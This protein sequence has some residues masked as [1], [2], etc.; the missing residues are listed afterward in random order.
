MKFG[1][2]PETELDTVDFSLPPEPA[3]NIKVLGG[4]RNPVAVRIGCPQWGVPGW[5]GKIYP[6]KAKEK[7]F[8]ANYVQHY[9]CIELNATHYKIYDPKAIGKWAEKDNGRDFF[10]YLK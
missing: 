1:K 9:N 6:P 4:V 10:V 8:L 3:G 5:V 2:V 7:D